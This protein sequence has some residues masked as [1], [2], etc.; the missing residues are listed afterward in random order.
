MPL[1]IA[2][3]PDGTLNQ[4]NLHRTEEVPIVLSDHDGFTLLVSLMPIHRHFE[5]IQEHTEAGKTDT[6]AAMI[7]MI[8]DH[9]VGW[10]DLYD[11]H[12]MPVPWSPEKNKWLKDLLAD[13]HIAAA[14]AVIK[15]A[16]LR[17]EAALGNSTPT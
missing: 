1:Y 3:N 16:Y 13:E 4:D 17:F 11:Q 7:A 6:T 14:I 10:K 2:I 8:E 5:I 9:V 12:K 15:K